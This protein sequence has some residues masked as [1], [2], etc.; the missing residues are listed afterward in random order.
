MGLIISS[1]VNS[2]RIGFPQ[3]Q[4]QNDLCSQNTH[5]VCMSSGTVFIWTFKW[6]LLSSQ[7]IEVT[8]TL[9]GQETLFVNSPEWHQWPLQNC[10]CIDL[11]LW[12]QNRALMYIGSTLPLWAKVSPVPRLVTCLRGDWQVTTDADC[13]THVTLLIA[14][15][16]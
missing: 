10:F 8:I 13:L 16:Y 14:E 11:L 9:R 7:I 6:V 2:S 15:L 12:K 4:Q 1:V 5:Y 3:Q